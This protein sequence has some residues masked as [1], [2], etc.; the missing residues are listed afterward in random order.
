M[1]SLLPPERL[2]Q[3][4]AEAQDPEKVIDLAPG[5]E[6]GFRGSL[7]PSMVKNRRIYNGPI[8]RI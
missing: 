6:A 8:G 4:V 2:G 7:M 5:K 1:L 3:L